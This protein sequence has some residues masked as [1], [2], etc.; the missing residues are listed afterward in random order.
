VEGVD[1]TLQPDATNLHEESQ[2]SLPVDAEFS[3]NDMH[4]SP[5]RFSPSHS[6]PSSS[7]PLPQLPLL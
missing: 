6:S 2:L 7:C 1:G 4:V 5:L 3:V